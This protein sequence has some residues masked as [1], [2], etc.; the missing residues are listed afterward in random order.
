[1]KP[2]DLCRLRNQ[3]LGISLKDTQL[4]F[5]NEFGTDILWDGISKIRS[6]E[7]ML[8]LGEEINRFRVMGRVYHPVIGRVGYVIMIHIMGIQ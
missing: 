4:C 1:M 2:G 8:Y 7:V 6:D 5:E 3:Y